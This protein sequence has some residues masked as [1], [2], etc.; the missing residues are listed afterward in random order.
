GQNAPGKSLSQPGNKRSLLVVGVAR[1][2]KSSSLVDGLSDSF[3]YLPLQQQYASHLTS[4]MT[5]A[6]RT[7][8]GQPATGAVR[9]LVASMTPNLP[10]VTSQTLEDSVALGLVPQRVAPAVCA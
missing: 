3:V 9:A 4:Q 2:I 8:P 6:A 7:N 5:I 10:I 1:D